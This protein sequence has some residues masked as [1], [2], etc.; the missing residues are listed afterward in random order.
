M[1]RPVARVSNATVGGA[2]LVMAVVGACSSPVTTGTSVTPTSPAVGTTTVGASSDDLAARFT[3]GGRQVY[4]E[5]HGS[6]RPTVVLQTGYGNAGDIWS[7][8]KAHPPCGHTRAGQDEP[9]LFLRPPWDHA[10]TRRRGRA[11]FRPN[12]VAVTRCPCRAAPPQSS[13]SCTIS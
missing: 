9:G 13:P 11:T 6:G 12:P 5:C 4:L 1:H 8:A 7:V 3:V 10:L 2:L